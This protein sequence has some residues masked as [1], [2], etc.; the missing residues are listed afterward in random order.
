M[1][2]LPELYE[3]KAAWISQC[4]EDAPVDVER[5][6]SK[7]TWELSA[8]T[9]S[10]ILGSIVA[11][12]FFAVV[13]AVRFTPERNRLVQAGCAAVV[14]WALATLFRYRASL[15]RDRLSAVSLARTGVEHY[16]QELR[17]R[18]DHLRGA[19]IWHGPLVLACI[20]SAVALSGRI[21]PRRIWD[22]L[23]IML[24]LVVWAGF[25]IRRRFRQAAELQKEIDRKE[26][27]I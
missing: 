18:R 21:V 11:A 17:R 10:E 20:T 25:G 16:R 22:A 12:L 27:T 6:Q 9:R 7:R 1:P 5:L 8:A 26:D 15:R 19:W 14:L 23:P 3:V 24:A 13:M 2:E 4:N